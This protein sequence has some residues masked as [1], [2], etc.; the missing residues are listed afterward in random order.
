MRCWR[1]VTVTGLS[2]IC[3]KKEGTENTLFQNCCLVIVCSRYIRLVRISNFSI[4]KC[5]QACVKRKRKK[6]IFI[7]KACG[8]VTKKKKRKR[9]DTIN[10]ILDLSRFTFRMCI[11]TIQ[12]L[13]FF[14]RQTF[15][16]YPTTRCLI[17]YRREH[18]WYS[19]TIIERYQILH[20]VKYDGN[21][22]KQNDARPVEKR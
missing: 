22:S 21:E 11:C 18:G 2:L 15:R 10:W 20:V 19:R 8:I 7:R 16:N 4:G 14:H 17:F 12:L 3:E 5:L 13:Y 6:F 9:K 1:K